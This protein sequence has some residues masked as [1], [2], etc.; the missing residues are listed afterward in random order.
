VGIARALANR[1]PVLLADEPTGNLD[2]RSGEQVL[3]LLES[4]RREQGCAVLL[5]THEE[6]A[7]ARADRVLL[8][9][10]GRLRAA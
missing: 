10:G 9:E 6:R 8:L 4:A 5:V 7:A 2:M 3:Q 1:P